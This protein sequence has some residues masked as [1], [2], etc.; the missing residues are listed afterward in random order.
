MHEGQIQVNDLMQ[1]GYCYL[2]TEPVG[3]NFHPDLRPE[4]TPKQMLELGVFGGKYMTDCTNEFPAD[5]FDNAKLCSECHDP[6]LN[7]F[8]INASQPLS[9]WRWRGWIYD[10]DP[11]GWCN[12]TPPPRL[13]SGLGCGFLPATFRG[14]RRVWVWAVRW[15]SN[16][17]PVGKPRKIGGFRGVVS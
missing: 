7:Y 8:G 1:T 5:W 6:A 2:L 9:E 10:D 12:R 16:S 17:R 4:L 15:T 3:K 14:R 11:R 13:T